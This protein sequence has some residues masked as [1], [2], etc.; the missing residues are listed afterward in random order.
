MDLNAEEV[1]LIQ[2]GQMLDYPQPEGALVRLYDNGVCFAVGEWSEK[3]QM[4]K[5]KRVFNLHLAQAQLQ[6]DTL[7]ALNAE[8]AQVKH[9]VTEEAS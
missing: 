4:L 7:Q 8:I 2:H 6:Q 9:S 1:D 3:K 5:A